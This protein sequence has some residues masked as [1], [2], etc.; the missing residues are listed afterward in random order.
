MPQFNKT[1]IAPT[2]SGYLHMGNALSF[3]TTAQIAQQTGAK[4]LLR[5]KTHNKNNVT[6]KVKKVFF[7]H[8]FSTMTDENNILLIRKF[9]SIS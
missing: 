6:Q 2:P 3:I 7:K 8:I 5:V 9:L 1:R 4:L